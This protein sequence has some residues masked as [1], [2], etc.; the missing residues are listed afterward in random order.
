MRKI[1]STAT[2]FALALACAACT[3]SNPLS[4]KKVDYG[5]AT[6][7]K[8]PPLEVPPDLVKPGQDDR[9]KVPDAQTTTFSDYTLQRNA[10]PRIGTTDVLPVFDK[11]RLERAGNERW[12]VVPGTPEQLWPQIKE[13]WA[14]LGFTLKIDSPETGVMETDWK[15]NR[16][17]I[18]QDGLRKYVGM[19]FDSLW[20]S[21]EKDKFRTRLERSSQPGMTEI[22]VSHRGVEEVVNLPAYS[23]SADTS[24]WQT[25]APDPELEAEI[26]G[27]MLVKFGAQEEQVKTLLSD[28]G[29]GN[30]ARIVDGPDG[31]GLLEV[32][33]PFDRA[34]RRIGLALDRVG[35]TVEDR[36]RA[37][38]L[39]F[40]R[41]VDPEAD[42]KQA[43]KS[44]FKKLFGGAPD[45][46][47]A[48]Y[49]IEVKDKKDNSQVQVQS[50]EGAPDKTPTGKK[51]LALL[52][53]QL[54]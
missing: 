12:L 49:R 46:T 15:E 16:S 41:Y 1:L 37:K 6:T 21:G 52:Q 13:F 51:I 3:I 34:W 18:P 31:S 22:Y 24:G 30:R 17:K 27:R 40:V 42:Q 9:F 48:R 19:V 5:S 43:E 4:S 38:G 53:D 11:V 47:A 20:S 33:E 36:D 14:S 39:Y 26:L 8:L 29:Q 50:N 35:F 28:K 7:A 32:S 54:K 25:R 45:K 44:F 23:T 2:W 10:G